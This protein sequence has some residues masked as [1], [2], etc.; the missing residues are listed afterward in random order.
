MSPLMSW[1]IAI[2]VIANTLAC[3]WLIWWT[4][5]P[6][7]GEEPEGAEKEHVWDDDLRELNNPMPRWWLNLFLITVVFSLVYYVLYPGL[8]AMQG[9]LG[10]TS[11]E[12]H[13]ARLAEVQQ[14]RQEHFSRYAGMD[15]DVLAAEPA[16]MQAAARLY[17]DQ[18][19]G[20]HG[21]SAEGA[22]GFP[23]LRDGDWLYGG[24]PA[25]IL[26]SIRHGRRGVMPAHLSL[27]APEVVED[28]VSLVAQWDSHG[29]RG[30]RLTAAQG[31]YA[32]SCAACHGAEAQG[33]TQLGAPN[34][35]NGIWV[36]GGSRDAIRNSV[37]FGRQGEM[38]AFDDLL[39]DVEIHLLA[40]YLRWVS[41]AVE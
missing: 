7:P 20:C 39:G 33:N 23:S 30:D 4:A 29:L 36:Y 17:A 14:Q 10:W 6:R 35:R 38:P 5:R 1:V 37:L 40:G 18:C 27:L 22:I 9:M 12:Q 41:G 2:V 19:A 32:R 16:A 3:I 34:L 8:G 31:A 13:D 15:V 28:L 11:T 26:H 25:Q 21:P 24:E